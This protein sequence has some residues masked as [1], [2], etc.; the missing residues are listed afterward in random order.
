MGAIT[1]Q[2]SE[3]GSCPLAAE[4]YKY[5]EGDQNRPPSG[6]AKKNP[7]FLK[8]SINLQHFN[9]FKKITNR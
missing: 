9:V 5:M 1:N 7:I 8:K 2:N 6:I 4:I 3:N